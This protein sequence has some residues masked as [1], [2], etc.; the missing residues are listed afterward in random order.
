[1]THIPRPP[2]RGEM[3]PEPK[4]RGARVLDAEGDT[5]RRGTRLWTCEAPID[6]VRVNAVARVTWNHLV[7][8]Y[9]PLQV[10]DLNDRGPS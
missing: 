10:L 9:G 4:R 1:M 6:G 5:W 8:T 3:P 7:R 2:F